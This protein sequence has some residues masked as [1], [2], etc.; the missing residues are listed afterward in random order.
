MAVKKIFVKVKLPKWKT[1]L[2]YDG[3]L[4]RNGSLL[5]IPENRFNKDFMEKVCDNCV[6]VLPK[7]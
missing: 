6:V 4:Y 7:K 5:Q 2:L 3:K 1:H